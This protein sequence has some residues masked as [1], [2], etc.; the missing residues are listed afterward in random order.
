VQTSIGKQPRHRGACI[1][2]GVGEEKPRAMPAGV[3]AQK[4]GAKLD[5]NQGGVFCAE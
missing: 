3:C 2:V 5:K 1:R 4:K